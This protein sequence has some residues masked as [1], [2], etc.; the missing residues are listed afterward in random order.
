MSNTG[1]SA[2]GQNQGVGWMGLL[3]WDPE[4]VFTSRIIQVVGRF[5]GYKN[6]VPPHVGSRPGKS[7]ARS[8][9]HSHDMVPLP[10]KAAV[11]SSLW[12]FHFPHFLLGYLSL[13]PRPQ[14]AQVIGSGPV[15]WF[16]YF[17]VSWLGLL[18]TYAVS[19]GPTYIRMW[20]KNKGMGFL[21]GG[22]R[23]S[24]D[25]VCHTRHTVLFCLPSWNFWSTGSLCLDR[26]IQEFTFLQSVP[27]LLP[28][29]S[30]HH[31]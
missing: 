2:Q 28:V 4:E 31:T 16:P 30:W 3:P 26:H 7:S 8:C 17:K 24:S 5:M 22:G 20:L 14:R 18:I 29:P 25:S 27:R 9:L 1:F 15:G 10:S 19:T 13:L 23:A 6:E 12:A 11:A 21:I